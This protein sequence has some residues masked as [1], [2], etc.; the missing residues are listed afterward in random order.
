MNYC[1]RHAVKL[2]SGPIMLFMR[3]TSL[4]NLVLHF[5][6][7]YHSLIYVV[8]LF[9]TGGITLRLTSHSQMLVRK[10]LASVFVSVPHPESSA[11]SG[12]VRC[13]VF[14]FAE[15]GCGGVGRGV[16]CLEVNTP[17]RQRSRQ[18]GY[19]CPRQA[20]RNQGLQSIQ[21]RKLTRKRLMMSRSP[22]SLLLQAASVQVS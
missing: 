11:T 16:T 4:K 20:A 9:R 15:R 6:L 1:D 21:V 10:R 5:L 2:F 12:G 7:L 3:L 22:S 14:W 19:R 17:S 8:L 18:R 13:E